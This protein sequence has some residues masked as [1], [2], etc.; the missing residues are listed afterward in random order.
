MDYRENG[1]GFIVEDDGK[2]VAFLKKQ[3]GWT[4]TLLDDLLYQINDESGDWKLGY[5]E[6]YKNGYQDW[7][8]HRERLA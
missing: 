3:V 8:N 1:D 6:G 4:R 2:Q 5:S 7:A